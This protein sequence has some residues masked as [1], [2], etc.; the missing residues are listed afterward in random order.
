MFKKTRFVI[1]LVLVMMLVLTPVTALADPTSPDTTDGV[2]TT[3]E[4]IWIDEPESQMLVATSANFDF[5]ID[6]HGIHGMED[7]AVEA[8]VAHPEHDRLGT[9]DGDNNWQPLTTAGQIIFANAAG[10]GFINESSYPVTVGLE[11]NL[12]V[13]G[14]GASQADGAVVPVA[15]EAAV[16]TNS[17]AN[18]FIGATFS[19]DNVNAPIEEANF[20]ED[21]FGDVTLPIISAARSAVFVLPAALYEDD[22][23]VTNGVVT[24]TRNADLVE[25]SGSGTHLALAGIANC[26]LEANW[27]ILNLD[28]DPATISL[29]LVATW[30]ESTAWELGANDVVLEDTHTA[31]GLVHREAGGAPS[32][33]PAIGLPAETFVVRAVG[34]PRDPEQQA[35]FDATGTADTARIA[36]N[37]AWTTLGTAIGTFESHIPNPEQGQIETF[38]QAI[39]DAEDALGTAQTALGVAQGAL[40]AAERD[41]GDDDINR[42]NLATAVG[43]LQEEVT[44]LSNRIGAARALVG[45]SAEA[46]FSGSVLTINA[47]DF[48][49][50]TGAYTVQIF[51]TRNANLVNVGTAEVA[52][53][54]NTQVNITLGAAW[55]PGGSAQQ[56]GE[57]T[58]LVLTHAVSGIVVTVYRNDAGLPGIDRVTVY[59]P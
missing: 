30:Q 5:I 16:T 18:V 31:F 39:S 4:V 3:P 25:G 15:T 11:L 40:A 55:L 27:D 56:S 20:D 57:S 14:A 32:T 54:N 12:T 45:P 23:D 7:S 34:S 43:R 48:Q 26:H 44:A 49:F 47:V 36:A 1:A 17:A 38:E 21:F 22:V 24:V 6:P 41:L 59:V 10:G 2:G 8:L 33:E 58:H 35:A 53:I 9:L 13:V 42:T 50:P 51:D 28:A 29:R 46:F 19:E 52:R 37:T